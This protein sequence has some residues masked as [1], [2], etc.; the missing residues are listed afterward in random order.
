MWLSGLRIQLCSAV[1]QVTTVVQV[2]SLAQVFPHDEGM[3]KKKKKNE[4]S[5]TVNLVW[6]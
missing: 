2:Q 5:G 4:R 1:A 3:T 6:A